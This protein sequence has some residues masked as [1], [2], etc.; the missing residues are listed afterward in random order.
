MTYKASIFMY[1]L[2]NY[3]CS[4][5]SVDR[6]LKSRIITKKGAKQF[7]DFFNKRGVWH[8]TLPGGEPTIHPFFIEFIEEL[9]QIHYVRIITNMSISQDK[10][11]EFVNR[12]SPNKIDFF[13]CSLQEIDDD[14][15]NLYK[16][17][18]KIKFLKNNG[19]KVYVDYVATPK[20]I[21]KIEEKCKIFK[22]NS[23]PFSIGGINGLIDEKKYPDSYNIDEK[24]L[25][26][27]K[28]ISAIQREMIDIGGVRKSYGRLCKAGFNRIMINCVTGNIHPC[29]ENRKTII[30]NIYDDNINLHNKPYLCDC[31]NCSCYDQPHMDIEELTQ[32]DINNILDNI[33]NYDVDIYKKY[34]QIVEDVQLYN[35][36]LDII[37]KEKLA[38][39][40]AYS[41]NKNIGIYGTGKH[42]QNLISAYKRLMNNFDCNIYYINSEDDAKEK[43]FLGSS[44]YHYKD[45][46]TLNLDR[47]IISSYMYQNE[48]YD[49][50]KNIPKINII[51]IYEE[52]E[53]I[54]FDTD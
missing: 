20:R 7:T 30:G 26:D 12:I 49:L 2:C 3:K 11:N 51:K 4:Y 16:F 45:I 8:I 27:S 38:R 36:Y 41:K 42:T 34:K 33:N 25:L 31:R 39:L 14:G 29:V 54:I 44:I 1:G 50:L 18:D 37:K 52:N 48:I 23:I 35:N 13:Q 17:L 43:R 19:F 10:L 22:E 53:E 46:H 21:S 5:C 24:N 9:T 40:F 32:K 6:T 28:M 15:E 47:I